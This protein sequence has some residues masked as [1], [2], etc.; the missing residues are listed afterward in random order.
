MI[1]F[2]AFKIVKT[3]F[4]ATLWGLSSP[5]VAIA[6]TWLAIGA[7]QTY[8]WSKL[9]EVIDNFVHDDWQAPISAMNEWVFS[10]DIGLGSL[11]GYCTGLD[12]IFSLLMNLPNIL[13]NL[14]YWS[15]WIFIDIAIALIVYRYSLR[16]Y[17]SIRGVLD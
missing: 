13:F 14:V 15:I 8:L 3:G 6:A 10:G 16:F 9:G 12:T 2:D 11:I 4:R 1:V 5:A 7:L 17:S